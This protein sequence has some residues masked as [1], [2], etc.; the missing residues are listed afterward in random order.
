MRPM[1]RFFHL[2]PL[3]AIAAVLASC[4][5]SFEERCRREA[6]DFSAKQ[7]PRRLDACT[8]LDSMVF[9]DNPVGFNYC[10]S[11]SGQ[12]DADSI[13]E[14]AERIQ[15]YH[16]GLVQNVRADIGLR[17]CKEHGFTFSYTY[18]SATTGRMLMQHV[19]TPEDY[20]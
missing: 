18:V 14:D 16:D 9:V 6:A 19:I 3:L 1:R 15:D 5:E 8:T 13:Y 20:K 10:Y 11:V 4:A 12:L 17:Q 2:F 7:C